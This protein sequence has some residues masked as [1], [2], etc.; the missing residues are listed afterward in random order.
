[1][2]LQVASFIDPRDGVT[3]LT[4][5][6]AYAHRIQVNMTLNDYFVEVWLQRS[7]Q[8]AALSPPPDPIKKF[9]LGPGSVLIPEVPANS[10]ANPPVAAV[11]AVVMPDLN[12]FWGLVDAV[13]AANPSN[14][15]LQNMKAAVDGVIKQLAA[16][17]PNTVV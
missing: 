7:Q 6:F 9:V 12:T 17:S 1:M 3:A 4:N 11:P 5:C 13:K 16:L 2:G 10:R 8:A 15:T 14:T